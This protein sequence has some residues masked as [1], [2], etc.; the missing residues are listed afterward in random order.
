VISHSQKQLCSRQ[1][2]VFCLKDVLDHLRDLWCNE[3][4]PNLDDEHRERSIFRKKGKKL[5]DREELKYWFPRRTSRRS[6]NCTKARDHGLVPKFAEL[7]D[8]IHFYRTKFESW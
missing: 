5:V 8:P 1:A 4:I 6:R 7:G 2:R 3:F